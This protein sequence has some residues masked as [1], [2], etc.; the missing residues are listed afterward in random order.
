M[1]DGS[2]IPRGIDGFN[3]YIITTCAFLSA[4]TPTNAERL[5][6]L[7]EEAA[8]W[9][10][11]LAEWTPL[12]AKYMDKKISRTT[13]V[14]DQLMDIINRCVLLD[15][16]S[17]ILDRIAASPN[18]TI[19]DMETFNIKKGILQKGTRTV[20]TTPINESVLAALQ[21]MGG[22]SFAVKCH[23]STS[24]ASIVDGADS[25]QYAYLVGTT[26]PESV[27]ADG[28]TKDLSTK[29]AFTLPLGPENS[30][31]YLYIYFRWY[32]TKHPELAGTWS[33]LQTALIV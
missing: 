19:A 10:G 18:V 25:V 23:N 11:F 16:T 7:T 30:A 22:G 8:K 24:R 14:K 12:Y 4:G 33:A 17:H 31:K 21:S 28:L 20:P 3:L 27:K 15:Q 26:P 13:A 6:I 2:R 9:C 1:A 5:G 29:A 32:N